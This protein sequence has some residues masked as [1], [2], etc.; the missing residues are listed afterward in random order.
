MLLQ[1]TCLALL[2]GLL[3]SEDNEDY[4]PIII[5]IPISPL[6][7]FLEPLENDSGFRGTS[8]CSS[9]ERR[10]SSFNDPKLVRPSKLNSD[11]QHETTDTLSCAASFTSEVVSEGS[12]RSAVG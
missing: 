9:S 1:G 4:L 11:T 3:I 5:K 12:S 10:H 2:G 7:K 8:T 6:L